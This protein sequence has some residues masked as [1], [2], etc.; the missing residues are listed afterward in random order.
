VAIQARIAS[1]SGRMDLSPAQQELL[2]SLAAD[3]ARPFVAVDFG[4]P[5]V[6]TLAPKL[7]ALLLTY[8]FGDATEAAAVQALLGEAPIGG[9]LPISIPDLFPV[10]YGLARAAILP[11]QPVAGFGER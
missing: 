7:P 4:N 3:P 2:E 9:T 1:Y 10:G 5:Y 8:D 6:A 11:G